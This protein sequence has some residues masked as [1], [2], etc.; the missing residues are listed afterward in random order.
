MLLYRD[1][2][3]VPRH[4]PIHTR[5]D[6]GDG[7]LGNVPG[8][9]VVHVSTEDDGGSLPWQIGKQQGEAGKHEEVDN[10]MWRIKGCH[11]WLKRGLRVDAVPHAIKVTVHFTYPTTQQQWQN[12]RTR[13]PSE[14]V[15]SRL[16]DHTLLT[17]CTKGSLS[18]GTALRPPSLAL[19]FMHRLAKY[20]IFA[21]CTCLRSTH[22][23]RPGN[24]KVARG[25]TQRG[26]YTQGVHH[27]EVRTKRRKRSRARFYSSFALWLARL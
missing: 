22:Y 3:P 14:S 26:E 12:C 11:M 8:A 21:A 20:W 16:S 17:S 7:R 24:E 6:R 27:E 9:R 10:M 4:P 18:L 15:T 25:E 13:S 5:N 23:S 2:R 19:I 1:T